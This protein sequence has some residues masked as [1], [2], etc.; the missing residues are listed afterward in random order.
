MKKS[1]F[2]FVAILSF[3]GCWE[4]EIY[5]EIT[6]K[7]VI[8]HPPKS[9]RINDQSGALND[10]TSD[11][12]ASI[13]VNVIVHCAHCTNAQSR[14]FGSDFD[15]YIRITLTEKNTTIAR[16]QM[17]YK[18]SP[19]R[20]K[21]HHVYDHLIRTMRWGTYEGY[22]GKDGDASLQNLRF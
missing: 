1:L 16:A 12:T 20:E 22:K 13:S 15:G 3:G 2:L 4:Q 14:S 10:V 7:S 21:I 19:D 11:S 18:G 6:D 5:T 8:D 9:V 17:D